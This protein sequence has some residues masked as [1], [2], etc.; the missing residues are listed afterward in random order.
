[1][2]VV[3]LLM[4][5]KSILKAYKAIRHIFEGKDGQLSIKRIIGTIIVYQLLQIIAYGVKHDKTIQPEVLMSL[6]S[7]I[8]I[9]FGLT[10]VPNALNK[11]K[12]AFNKNTSQNDSDDSSIN[13]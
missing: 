3:I 1:M 9:F 8:T 4:F 5:W 10:M 11:I 7:L 6:V 13:P 2:G 12:S